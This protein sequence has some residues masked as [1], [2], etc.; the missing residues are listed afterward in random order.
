MWKLLWNCQFHPRGFF[1]SSP[2]GENITWNLILWLLKCTW[3]TRTGLISKLLRSRWSGHRAFRGSV[4]S[5]R[6]ENP[7]F[8]LPFSVVEIQV[9]CAWF[10]L[11]SLRVYWLLPHG[12]LSLGRCFTEKKRRTW[13]SFS[14]DPYVALRGSQNAQLTNNQTENHVCVCLRSLG[15]ALCVLGQRRPGL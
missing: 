1:F 10:R 15:P 4:C 11:A 8:S 2:A 9:I 5:T 14:P 6:R 3:W 13:S 12:R 7:V